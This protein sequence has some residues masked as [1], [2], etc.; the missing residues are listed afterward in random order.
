[1]HIQEHVALDRCN[2]LGLPT[3]AR[4]LIQAGCLKDVQEALAFARTRELPLIPLGEGSNVVFSGDLNA[5]VLRMAIASKSVVS[6][7]GDHIIVESGAGENWHNFVRWTLSQQAYGLE[8]LSLIPGT[9]GAAP[10]QNIGAY[11]VEL[12]D[13]FHSLQAIDCHTGGI[14]RFNRD[15]CAF[16][17]RDSVFKGRCRDCYV[18]TSLQ[19][20][21]NTRLTPRLDYAN[22]RDRI[23]KKALKSGLSAELISDVICDIRREKLPDPKELGNV[24]S[25]FKNPQVSA[26]K[27]QQLKARYPDLVAFPAD[28][29]WK[30]AAGWLIDKAGLKGVR[31]GA[32]GTHKQQ[33]L[34][35]VN[36]G[37]ATG[38]EVL[39]FSDTIQAQVHARFGVLLEREPRVY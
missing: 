32:V 4:Y 16:D 33:A 38:Q 39:C 17:Y 7:L 31:K 30:L 9:V 35:L 28:E 36:H 5:V 21:L 13:V 29:Q 22:L 25:F 1:M 19:L 18:I 15:D 6:T 14:V 3:R 2:T 8:N 24:G 34:V 37:G 12:K 20:K 11:G 26:S 10:I 23:E 27:V